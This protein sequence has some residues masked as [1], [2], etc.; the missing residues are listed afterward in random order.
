MTKDRAKT[1]LPIIEAYTQNKVIQGKE[2]DTNKWMDI[3]FPCTPCW[4][5][6]KDYRI[7]PEPK[8]I[9]FTFEDMKNV[10][11]KWIYFNNDTKQL[12]RINKYTDTRVVFSINSNNTFYNYD[13]LLKFFSF[14]D[15][16]PCGKLIEDNG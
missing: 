14:E 16:T 8:Y 5:D 12:M 2:K 4:L 3:Q 1:L 10:R 9:P 13:D 15:G 11:D 6:N 7:K